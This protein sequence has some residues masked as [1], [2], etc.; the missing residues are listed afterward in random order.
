MDKSG[1]NKMK[2]VIAN[3]PDRSVIIVLSLIFP[4]TKKLKL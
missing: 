2:G 1:G 3:P 4:K